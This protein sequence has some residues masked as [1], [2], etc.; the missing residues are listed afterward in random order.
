MALVQPGTR[1][2]ID[3]QRMGSLI[4]VPLRM[5]RI[6]PFGEG[7][8]FFSLNSKDRNTKISNDNQYA[9][10]TR[11]TFNSSL[12]RRYGGA[13]YAHTVLENGQCRVDGHLVVRLITVRQS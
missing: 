3:L 7:H 10:V 9:T 2:G 6:V 11:L 1:R 8:I 12:I 4:T 5:F 13:L